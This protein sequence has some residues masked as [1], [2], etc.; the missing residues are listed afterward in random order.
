M[1]FEKLSDHYIVQIYESI[2]DQV[3]ADA[4][5][6]VR[7]VGEPARERAERLREEIDRRG[8]FCKPIEWPAQV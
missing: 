8:L 5:S 2:R 4:T 7:L 3:L 1:P 6:G